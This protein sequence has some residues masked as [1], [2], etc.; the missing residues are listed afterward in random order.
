VDGTGSAFNSIQVPIHAGV[1][2]HY[3]FACVSFSLISQFEAFKNVNFRQ[4][5]KK[6]LFSKRKK[7]VEKFKR[8][9]C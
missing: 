8:V 6:K 1:N 5:T 2:K 9:F 4:F 3:S 7:V